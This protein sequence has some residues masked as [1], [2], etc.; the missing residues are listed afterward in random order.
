M[1]ASTD[2]GRESGGK[3]EHRAQP[4]GPIPGT[5]VTSPGTGQPNFGMEVVR[6]PSLRSPPHSTELRPKKPRP[7][8]F[9]FIFFRSIF[10]YFSFSFLLFF[11]FSISQLQIVN[12]GLFRLQIAP[13]WAMGSDRKRSRLSVRFPRPSSRSISLGPPSLQDKARINDQETNPGP[14]ATSCMQHDT[15][16]SMPSHAIPCHP[17]CR[18]R[19]GPHRAQ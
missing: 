11:G 12:V 13:R 3:S 4:V 10:C 17:A 15:I 16:A 1:R 18:R 9:F 5:D 14:G 2:V 19:D 7:W 6:A 8:H